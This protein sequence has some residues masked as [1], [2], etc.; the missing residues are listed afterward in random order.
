M[1]VFYQPKYYFNNLEQKYKNQFLKI[2]PNI[3]VFIS[4]FIS[5]YSNSECLYAT[6]E[7]RINEIRYEISQNFNPEL[8]SDDFEIELD[9]FM[10]KNYLIFKEIVTKFELLKEDDDE[11]DE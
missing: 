1:S 4:N 9:K 8:S 3:N 2:I 6:L 11:D 10:R 7:C 5:S